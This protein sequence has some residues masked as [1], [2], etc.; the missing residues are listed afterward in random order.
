MVIVPYVLAAV[1]GYL[2]GSI[3]VGLVVVWLARGIDVRRV[4]SGRTGGTNALRAAGW[5]AGVAT[6]VGDALKGL[7]A[8]LIVR[9][10]FQTSE[11]AIIAGLATM[12][13]HNWSAYIGF[14]GGA[15]TASNLGALLGLS[16]VTCV[17]AF[18]AG[19]LASILWRIASV[20]SLTV[21]VVAVLVLVILFLI[22]VHPVIYLLYAFGQLVLVVVALVPNIQRLIGGTE[23][24]VTY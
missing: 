7:L 2:L 12:V 14:K 24:P 3:P 17:L 22:H 10:V 18:L 11:A 23:R 1:F 6:G 15:G 21:S 8:V 20:A 13:G 5:G 9:M 19:I 16:P 4:G